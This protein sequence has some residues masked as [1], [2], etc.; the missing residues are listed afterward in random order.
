LNIWHFATPQRDD[1]RTTRANIADR[2]P[3]AVTRD[4]PGFADAA[5]WSWMPGAGRLSAFKG[6]TIGV[7]VMVSGIAEG[8]ALQHAK[9]LAARALGG[10][11]K[12]G[13]AYEGAAPANAA[14]V[15][16]VAASAREIWRFD[17][18][19]GDDQIEYVNLL[20]DSVQVATRP[21]QLAQVKWFFMSKQSGETISG[22]GHFAAQ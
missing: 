10:A 18:L 15:R 7:D 19:A 5:L 16:G 21:D 6:G 13:F 9:V 2:Q 17:K 3:T 22:M 1:V 14:Q 4:L 20:I 11:A 8:A 12:A